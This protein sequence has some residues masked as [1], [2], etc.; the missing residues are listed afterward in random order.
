[1]SA[2]VDSVAPESVANSD[3]AS[4]E[5]A[6]LLVRMSVA[7]IT[8]TDS[9]QVTQNQ[10][11]PSAEKEPNNSSKNGTKP[12]LIRQDCT[13]SHL[14]VGPRPLLSAS[15][16]IGYGGSEESGTGIV[17]EENSVRSVPDIEMHCRMNDNSPV[18]LP[19]EG[20]SGGILYHPN[21]GANSHIRL[22]ESSVTGYNHLSPHTRCRCEHRRE[23]HTRLSSLP[24]SVSRESVRSIGNQVYQ[25]SPYSAPPAV[26]L[27]TT[28]SSSRVIRQSSQPESSVGKS[29][30]YKSLSISQC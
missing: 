7:T 18:I 15:G 9:N 23:S 19:R 11:A 26:L 8:A 22:R 10:N 6:S 16:G 12:V 1:M 13:T 17:I 14:S 29:V 24:R 3:Y 30:I 20:G 21:G 25:Y 27:T 4:D 2:E 5:T 28:S